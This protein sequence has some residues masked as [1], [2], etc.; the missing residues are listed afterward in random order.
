MFNLDE[1]II[2]ITNRCNLKCKMCDIPDQE[3]RE[4]ETFQWKQVIDGIV[5]LGVKI[6]VFSGGE[7]LLRE[8]L[9]E[10]INYAKCKGLKVCLTSNG[11]F[12]N[13]SLVREFSAASVDVVNISIEGPKDIHEYLRGEATF[14]KALK[15]LEL[16]KKNNI[17]STISTMICRYNYL[18]LPYIVELAKEYGVTT[19]K[20]QPFNTLF[21]KPGKNTEHFFLSGDEEEK[22]RKLAVYVLSLCN[23]YGISTNPRAY[24]E[25]IAPYLGKKVFNKLKTCSALYTSL[26][27]NSKGEL[28]P[29]WVLTNKENMIAD[30]SRE[31][32]EDIWD[33][34]K[35]RNIIKKI[36]KKGCPGCILSCYDTN[37]GAE[38][39]NDKLTRSFLALRRDGLAEFINQKYGSLLKKI[40]FYRTYRGNFFG[41]ARRISKLFR[42][43]THDHVGLSQD[44]LSLLSEL[45]IAKEMLQ[46]E[47][48]SRK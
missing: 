8:D 46:R 11:T 29:C 2:S 47:I 38:Q 31:R 44:K 6:L 5:F 21:L 43:K 33:S 4:L 12:L 48:K 40:N 24:F 19:V 18:Y 30:L 45:D 7:P 13:D 17:D 3:Y 14:G 36:V 20:F 1:A 10:L 15:A 26:P 28:F 35:H 9:L 23:E 39:I 34:E 25:K 37:F 16:L 27:I 22:F 32:L 41:I 42:S